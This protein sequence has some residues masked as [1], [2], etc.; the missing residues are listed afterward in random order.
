[1]TG[2]T[3]VTVAVVGGYGAALTFTVTRVP[4]G[5]E[6]IL[7]DSLNVDHGGKG[8]NQAVAARRLGA[9]VALVTAV[10]PDAFGDAGRRLWT[11]EGIDATHV[12]TGRLPTMMGAILLE[13]GGENRIVVAMG[14]LGELEVSDV[15]AFADQIGA[16]DVCVV[17]LEVPAAVAAKALAVAK[18]R[19]TIAILNP[20][21]AVPLPDQLVGDVDV[22]VPNRSEAEL[23]SGSAPGTDPG[24]LVDRLRRRT[25]AKIVLTLGA[26][27]TIVDDGLARHHV[28]APVPP[29]VVDTTGAGDAFTGALATG[30]ARG[31]ELRAAAEVAVSAAAYSVGISSV[32]PSLPRAA[33]LPGHVQA[34]MGGRAGQ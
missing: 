10:G 34:L 17:S 5:G 33:D 26:D 13:P 20:A 7:A 23:L 27:G 21:P 18:E 12:R 1:M 11:E 8:S 4:G 9:Q 28:P 32:V 15:A 24:T 6:T 25:G 3:Q 14:A 29:T 19:G 2:G 16:A 22:I 31:L 30:L